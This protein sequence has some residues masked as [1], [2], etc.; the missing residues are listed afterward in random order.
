MMLF[1][2]Y[3]LKDIVTCNSNYDDPIEND[4]ERQRNLQYHVFFSN[5]TEE[6]QTIELISGKIKT[7]S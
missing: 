2:D 4:P 5:L 1:T 3:Y 6:Q 7:T